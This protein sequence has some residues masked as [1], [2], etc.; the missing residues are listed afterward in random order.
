MV[1]QTLHGRV[2][3]VI[4][5]YFD[6]TADLKFHDVSEIQ[7]SVPACDN[8]AP[9]P[10][11]DDL[12]AMRMVDIYPYGKYILKEPSTSGDGVKE[13]KTVTAMS[14][15]WLL[16][17]RRLILEQ[18]TYRLY[19]A[20]DLTAETPTTIMGFVHA[21]APDW[22]V[23]VD[24]SLWNLYRTFDETDEGLLD[25][26]TN[27][28]ATSFGC[29]FC[30]DTYNKQIRVIDASSKYGIVP[31]YLSY[32][33]LIR[34][35]D[36]NVNTDDF[37]TV[38]SV[39]GADPVNI[40]EVNPIG[41]NKI[42]NLDYFIENGDLEEPLAS[43]WREWLQDI[44]D[45][46]DTFTTIST[47]RNLAR[48]RAIVQEADIKD[49]KAELTSVV[50]QIDVLTD[51]LNRTSQ[52]V[53]QVVEVGGDDDD[54]D[55]DSGNEEENEET[56]EAIVL[57]S[58]TNTFTGTSGYF[59]F[60]VKSG[61]SSSKIYV[62][63]A[64]GYT[65]TANFCAFKA[66]LNNDTT[67]VLI[68]G[69]VEHTTFTPGKYNYTNEP[70][71]N[72][73]VIQNGTVTVTQTSGSNALVETL[74]FSSGEIQISGTKNNIQYTNVQPN[75]NTNIVYYDGV[76]CYLNNPEATT[77]TPN[78]TYTNTS[79]SSYNPSGDTTL[80]TTKIVEVPNPVY[81]EILDQIEDLNE[82][83]ADWETQVAD[84]EAALEEEEENVEQFTSDLQAIVAQLSLDTYFTQAERDILNCYFI[85]SNFEDETFAVFDVDVSSSRES[86]FKGAGGTI[87][88]TGEKEDD[89]IQV[90]TSLIDL[91]GII[92]KT[93]YLMTAGTLHAVIDG[94]AKRTVLD[95]EILSGT[96]EVDTD[97][98][99]PQV[100]CAVYAGAGNIS[101]Y[102]ALETGGYSDE[103]ATTT[104]FVNANI[105]VIGA[106]DS[107]VLTTADSET[108]E[109]TTYI[110][111][112]V[113]TIG[114]G[115]LYF[116]RN[117]GYVQSYSVQKE[118][119]DY[120]KQKHVDIAHPSC[121]F[122]LKSGNIVFAEEFETFKDQLQ[123]GSGVYLELSDK[124]ILTPLLLEIHLD[125]ENASNFDLVFSNDFQRHDRVE[126]MRSI[127]EDAQQASR[128]LDMSKY[129][130]GAF[131]M[132]GAQNEIR[133]LFTR[134]I[135]ASTNQIV[136]SSDQSVVIDG[137]GITV[138]NTS[139]SSAPYIRINNGMI[140]LMSSD[141]SV[142]KLAIGRF[143]DSAISDNDIYGI[144][145]PSIVGTLL[146]GENLIIKSSKSYGGVQ[147]F[148]VDGS[149]VSLANGQFD[150]YK[151]SGSG[152][153]VSYTK[154]ITLNPDLGI[155]VG[156]DLSKVI[157]YSD[158]GQPLGVYMDRDSDHLAH[159]DGYITSIESART[160]YSNMANLSPNFWVDLNGDVFMRGT[161]Y[162]VGGVIDMGEVAV[163]GDIDAT[164][165]KGSIDPTKA[166][167]E[168]GYGGVG[169][170]TS[171]SDKGGI[172]YAVGDSST[173]VIDTYQNSATNYFLATTSKVRMQA[174]DT[175]Y[176]EIIKAVAASGETAAVTDTITLAAT[177]IT[178]NGGAVVLGDGTAVS[179][180]RN[181][182]NSISYDMDRYEPVFMDLLPAWYRLNYG[183][184]GRFH[185]GLVAQ[186]V[187]KALL[188]HGLT[189]SDFA[190]LIIRNNDGGE[191]RYALRYE[192]F[193]PLNIYMTQKL[194]KKVE[195]LEKE[196][197][198]YRRKNE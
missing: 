143:K 54:G 75:V 147:A 110:T 112:M 191:K 131:T 98:T 187:E 63:K 94:E 99:D 82:E 30:F 1:L 100:T 74:S 25:W 68:E 27:E 49:L 65:Y 56:L 167:I 101:T 114:E 117:S 115:G 150:L 175:S 23:D 179:S 89:I 5:T 87:T 141:S 145:G 19:N 171:G 66:E 113:G 177:E 162:A 174:G 22:S 46:Q 18:G 195:A 21:L 186:D 77:T 124:T 83:K 156:N 185:L 119:Y 78:A 72:T 15:E 41:S 60:T 93:V 52:Y 7:F 20:A 53:T 102:A 152:D 168:S 109:N 104:D 37:F 135:D 34:D 92:K 64:S 76:A 36:I 103:A 70:V 121:Q 137:T 184:S 111:S 148:Q 164:K 96:Y 81:Q 40:R 16:S 57:Q 108:L 45:S 178:L 133:N 149:G 146:A 107:V 67:H 24:E 88:I 35:Q 189:T 91:E 38:L 17:S 127:I 90:D 95:A 9:T 154:T 163:S 97:E 48:S 126:D 194:Y 44:D 193:V 172:I 61:D 51:T 122:E 14:L 192:E 62:P 198:K 176:I 157:Y 123:L 29:I 55:D 79:G 58:G 196:L 130:Y 139:D 188:D 71:S 47:M 153:N 116:T 132:S 6:L 169:V 33:N 2:I 86:Y 39:Y 134:M 84:A 190:G 166:K 159:L 3:G 28:A 13:V 26:L 181:V 31:I 12:D 142:A 160:N 73:I 158:S 105:T 10:F 161:I 140:S 129:N 144:A 80:P 183:T 43:R 165:L 151:A 8:G 59:S 11:Y 197:E 69:D 120:A 125:F 85:E 4:G 136:S 42:Y 173:Y 155:I 138:R 50:N 128:T 106:K 118:L 180:D 32:E 182:K 170:R